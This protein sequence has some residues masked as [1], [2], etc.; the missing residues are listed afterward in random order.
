MK[1]ILHL[2]SIGALLGL[3]ACEGSFEIEQGGAYKIYVQAIANSST[4]FITP[5][6]ATPVGSA[7]KETEFTVE[8]WLNGRS[9][10]VKKVEQEE[11]GDLFMALLVSEEQTGILPG[12]EIRIRVSCPDAREVSGTTLAY[13]PMTI[14]DV[15]MEDCLIYAN[16]RTSAYGKKIQLHLEKAPG[17]D[18][19]YALRI[20]TVRETTFDDGQTETS[21][22]Y[23]TPGYITDPMQAGRFDLEDYMSFNFYGS[24]LGGSGADAPITLLPEH[25]FDSDTYTFFLGSLD[26]N[27]IR[28]IVNNS[29][30]GDGGIGRDKDQADP[31]EPE[32]KPVGSRT[33]YHFTL[34]RLS[35]EF[36]YYAKALYQSNFDFLSNMGLTP[37]NFTYTN[38]D[39]GLG[40]V[41][42]FGASGFRVEGEYESL[43]EE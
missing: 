18:E 40:F 24:Y 19:H 10:E 37:A 31:K 22:A 4:L 8:A 42:Y 11:D 15:E 36:F 9:L 21:I 5:I 27:I 13:A 23:L 20:M 12:D 7:R 6:L 32:R 16:E 14:E 39:G 26:A 43:I 25:R 17:A 28:D 41:G 2:F 38:V 34:Y 30:E 3:G 29:P 33:S 35:P 1:R